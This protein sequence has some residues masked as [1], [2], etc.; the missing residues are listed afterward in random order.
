[1]IPVGRLQR[2]DQGTY[3]IVAPTFGKQFGLCPTERFFD[4]P[5]AADCSGF[6]IS[7]D[8]LVTAG[9]CVEGMLDRGSDLSSVAWVFGYLSDEVPVENVYSGTVVQEKFEISK[10]ID[11]A[12][13]RLDRKV[14][15][16]SPVSVA[17]SSATVKLGTR[18]VLAGFP[19]GIPLKLAEGSVFQTRPDFF[20]TDLDAFSIN[21]GS[22]V[23]NAETGEA[24]GILSAGY[25]DFHETQ[26]GC[27]ISTVYPD[28]SPM[29]VVSRIPPLFL[30]RQ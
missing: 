23:F 1:M 7:D 10:F 30:S 18:V 29:T 4:Q 28:S 13:I 9:H 8:L 16:F 22:L 12:L 6:L 24:E 5:S 17:D 15:R 3:K 20:V 27:S 26:A 19:S 14:T 21:S 25:G 2:T 11:Y